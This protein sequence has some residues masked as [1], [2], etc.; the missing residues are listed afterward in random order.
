[1]NRRTFYGAL[2]A[3]A[4]LIPLI[5]YQANRWFQ[6]PEVPGVSI[7]APFTLTASDGR[8]VTDQDFRGRY[9][10]IYFGFTMCVDAC[11]IAL[12]RMTAA[13]DALG[14]DGEAIQP[15]MV[16]VDPAR[17]TPEVLRDY[18]SAFHPRLIGL[19]GTPEATRALAAAYRVY[20]EPGAA[21]AAGDYQVDHS[22][23]VYLM[24]PDGGYITMYGADVEP[25]AMAEAI[26]D[27]IE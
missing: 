24:G 19:T 11:P 27:E 12:A 25:E 5:A 3:A 8:R 26:R 10:L 13:L 15:I 18:L 2:V 16:T 17:D 9:L 7:G 20:A 14:A 1:M 22:I 21:D 23:V 4:V 6:A